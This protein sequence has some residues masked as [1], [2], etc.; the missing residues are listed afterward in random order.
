MVNL[1]DLNPYRE[2]KKVKKDDDETKK[3]MLKEDRLDF[4]YRIYLIVGILYYLGD[5]LIK[6]YEMN[7]P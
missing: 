3:P 4:W 7:Y 2:I 1:L 5:T 6:V